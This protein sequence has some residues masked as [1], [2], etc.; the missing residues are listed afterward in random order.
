MFFPGNTKNRKGAT[1]TVYRLLRNLN[2]I[3][4]ANI[5]RALSKHFHLHNSVCSSPHCCQVGGV[6]IIGF[7]LYVGIWRLAWRASMRTSWRSQ[8]L[9]SSHSSH[10]AFSRHFHDLSHQLEDN[11]FGKIFQSWSLLEASCSLISSRSGTQ[12]PVITLLL[13]QPKRAWQVQQEMGFERVILSCSVPG[14]IFCP[15]LP[16]S[17]SMIPAC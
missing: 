17:P 9:V 13:C 16:N 8:G 6:R 15:F 12:S 1:Y 7:I 2:Q 3:N 10:P 11:A 14:P 4:N 5:C